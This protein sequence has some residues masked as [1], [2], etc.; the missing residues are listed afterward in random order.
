MFGDELV[1]TDAGLDSGS[2]ACICRFSGH[3]LLLSL[4]AILG[5]APFALGISLVLAGA[6]FVIVTIGL[7]FGIAA[8]SAGRPSGPSD[9]SSP[10]NGGRN[11]P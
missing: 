4:T 7:G 6:L 3:G 8:I 9:S 1:P 5:A 2:L 11:N 10:G